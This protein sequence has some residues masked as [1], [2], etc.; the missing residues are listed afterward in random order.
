M[1]PSNS[2][3]NYE[4]KILSINDLTMI[5][6]LYGCIFRL[7]TDV[8]RK[9]IEELGGKINASNKYKAQSLENSRDNNNFDLSIK[10]K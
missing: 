3:F 2:K 6:L 7:G 1:L 10:L 9:E 8:L 4:F 5:T